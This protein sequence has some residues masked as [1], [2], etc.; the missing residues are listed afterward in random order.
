MKIGVITSGGD[1][2]GMNIV[3]DTV[4]KLAPQ[5]GYEIVLIK[6]AYKGIIEEDFLDIKSI[7]HLNY[8]NDGGTVLG[9]VRFPEFADIELRKKAVKILNAH[10]IEALIVIGGDGSFQ[11]AS[12]LS[13]L[14]IKTIGIPATIDNDLSYS[15][16][17]LG[18]D[19]ASNFAVEAIERVKSTIIS[20]HR[21][22]FIE[23]MGNTRGDIALFSGLATN[24]DVIVIPEVKKSYEQIIAEV[25]NVSKKQEYIF[26][27]VSEKTYD[28]E[29]LVAMT[30]QETNFD[31]R[32]LVLGHL[33]RGGS[34]SIFDRVLGMKF[35]FKAMELLSQNVTDHCVG[36]KGDEIIAVPIGEAANAPLK[37]H[38]IL[39]RI[40]NKIEKGKE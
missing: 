7:Q 26:V 20:H 17:T 40:Y 19:T 9:S 39:E 12:E 3:I 2:P 28:L 4:I 15:E 11:G 23:V 25:K 14:G 16:K 29:K 30:K 38:D 1:A 32:S 10:E 35:A 37:R 13:K 34:P 8:R 31:T 6:N 18:F 33:Q 27:V 5:Y 22:L 21:C 24:A 36:N